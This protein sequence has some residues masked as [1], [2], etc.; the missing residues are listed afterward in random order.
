MSSF[1]RAERRSAMATATKKTRATLPDRVARVV[2]EAAALEFRVYRDNGGRYNWEIGAVGGESLVHS[3]S[4]DSRDDAERA[5]RR[6]YEGSR[7]ARF[8][9]EAP[10]ERQTAAV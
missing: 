2:P 9:L 10:E 8:E 6:V 4:F 7:S 1:R 5:A 3:P